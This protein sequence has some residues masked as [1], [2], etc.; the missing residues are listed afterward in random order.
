MDQ[1]LSA[2]A[3]GDGISVHTGFPNPALDHRSSG[4]QLT[5]DL[6]QLVIRRPAS[7]YLFRIAGHSWSDEGLYDSD[8]AVIDRSLTPRPQDLVLVWQSSGF[9]LRRQR[10]CLP[11]EST[12]GVVTAVL[13]QFRT[14][15]EGR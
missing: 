7:T 12:W 1:D 3:N 5:L 11:D 14:G 2:V 6:N 10:Q 8:I 9:G 4:G 15:N 13:H